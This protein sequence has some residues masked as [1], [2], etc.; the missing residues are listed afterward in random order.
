[1][2]YFTDKYIK[3]LLI[4]YKE[5]PESNIKPSTEKRSDLD[6]SYYN[7]VSNLY[8]IIITTILIEEPSEKVDKLTTNKP[9]SSRKKR[10]VVQNTNNW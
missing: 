5:K 8:I 2:G 3:R 1:L 7:N 10:L 4:Y 9:Y 6:L